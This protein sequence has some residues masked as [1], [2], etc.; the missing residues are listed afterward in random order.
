M[1]LAKIKESVKNIC[2]KKTQKNIKILQ[3]IAER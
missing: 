1:L 3:G 2:T